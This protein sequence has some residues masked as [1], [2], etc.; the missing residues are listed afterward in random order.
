MLGTAVLLI[1]TLEAFKQ[2]LD[3]TWAYLVLEADVVYQYDMNTLAEETIRNSLEQDSSYPHGTRNELFTTLFLYRSHSDLLS[4]SNLQTIANFEF[5]LQARPDFQKFC[6]A[7]IQF[8]EAECD[9]TTYQDTFFSNLFQ[10]V[11]LSEPA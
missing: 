4:P 10:G 3:R 8:P 1:L 11:N 9:V 5:E 2:N 7:R 6:Q